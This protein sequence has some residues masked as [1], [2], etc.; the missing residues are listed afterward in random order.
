[1]TQQG[2]SPG[3]SAKVRDSLGSPPKIDTPFGVMEF[4]DGVPTVATVKVGYEALALLRGI[5]VYLN[6]VPG[7]SMLAM[8]NGLRTVGARSNVIACT[9]PRSTSAPVVLTANTETTYGT[10]FLDLKNDGPT[11]VEAPPNSL[12]FVDDLWQR[13]VADMG[14]AGP[15]RGQGGKYVFLPPDHQGDVPDG[16]FVFQS[17]TYSNWVVIRALLGLDSLL[18]TRIYPL[19]AAADPPTTGFVDMAES[20][21]NGIH[22][23]DF[24]FFEEVNTI[25]QEEP[26]GTLDPE[27]AGQLAAIGIVKGRSFAPDDQQ[28]AILDQAAKIGAGLAR[29]LLYKPRDRAPYIYADGSWKTAFVGGSHE[30]LADG[31]RLLDCRTM[32]HY[33]GTGITPAMTHAAVGV[34]S[35]YAYTAE[36][37]TGAP[38]DGAR[39]YTLTLPAGIPAKTFWAID[40]Y[41][42]QT[43]SLLQTDNPYPSINNRFT[44]V[45]T[46]DNG[47]TILT[48]GPTPPAQPDT[49]WLQTLP[50][51][52]WFPILRLYGPLESWFDQTWRLGEIQPT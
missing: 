44:D 46:E 28:R 14:N 4:F 22:S 34:G 21:F 36:D 33:V 42:T 45:H 50:G 1:M 25:V 43:R 7:A 10:T 40:I 17:P 37:A 52:S 13:Y 18:T 2:L 3:V 16:Y 32:V 5:D 48:F 26:A 12:C 11:V 24:T 20:S 23:N 30:F 41:D 8:R 39:A 27:R 31:A 51:K 19:A 47:D 29:T 49:N 15:D 35:Q 38:L 9:D 6:C